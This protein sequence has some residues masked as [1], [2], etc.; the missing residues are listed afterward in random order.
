LSE[1][2]KK[3]FFHRETG[4]DRKQH[5]TD[6]APLQDITNTTVEVLLEGAGEKRFFVG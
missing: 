2:E 6:P 3:I 5:G 1:R 4:E